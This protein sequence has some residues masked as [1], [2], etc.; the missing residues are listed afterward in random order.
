VQSS[1]TA[2]LEAM[3]VSEVEPACWLSASCGER[4][5]DRN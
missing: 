3:L 2:T 4:G 5:E 1:L